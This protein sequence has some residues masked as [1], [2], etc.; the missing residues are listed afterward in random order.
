MNV[1]Q[2]VPL[3]IEINNLTF[4]CYFT[5]APCTVRFGLLHS[6]APDGDIR[7]WTRWANSTPDVAVKPDFR[8]YY[9]ASTFRRPQFHDNR[10]SDDFT[11]DYL[12]P[13]WPLWPVYG[14]IDW[15]LVMEI[16]RNPRNIRILIISWRCTGWNQR[17]TIHESNHS[18]GNRFIISWI[19]SIPHDS[20]IESPSYELFRHN[21]ESNN[22]FTNRKTVIRIK[23]LSRK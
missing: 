22:R 11:R 19:E 5:T 4:D 2:F 13:N 16:S 7:G 14:I 1:T 21:H 18:F 20:R 8:N 6:A 17:V 9:S 3:E 23:S 10:R 12:Q 15:V